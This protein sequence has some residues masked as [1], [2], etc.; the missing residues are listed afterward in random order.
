MLEAAKQYIE[1]TPL[2]IIEQY[3]AD[4]ELHGMHSDTA[5]DKM[6]KL[7]YAYGQTVANIMLAD[8]QQ[9]R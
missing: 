4:V 5:K 3:T 1:N 2:Q 8:L 6:K 7:I 9:H